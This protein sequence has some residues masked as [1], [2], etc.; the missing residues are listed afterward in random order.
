MSKLQFSGVGITAMNGSTGS[1]TITRN[2][3]GP[4]DKDRMPGVP[5]SPTTYSTNWQAIYSGISDAWRNVLSDSQRNAWVSAAVTNGAKQQV[6]RFRGNILRDAPLTGRDYFFQTAFNL[7]LVSFG[8]NYLVIPPQLMA[9]TEKPFFTIAALDPGQILVN[10]DQTGPVTWGVWY[11]T[12]NLSSGCMSNNK[13]FSFLY[14]LVSGVGSTDLW[15]TWNARFGTIPVTG[16]K[17]F[18]QFLLINAI[19][20]QR[21]LPYITSGIVA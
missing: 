6:K 3:Y 13:I 1:K 4:Y 16:E 12:N 21:S 7:S 15:T 17:I 14:F 10:F 18:I 9:M 11:A 2:A 20:G 5:W 8:V 19:T